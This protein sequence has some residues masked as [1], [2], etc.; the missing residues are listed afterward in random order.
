MINRDLVQINENYCRYRLKTNFTTVSFQILSQLS[1]VMREC[2]NQKPRAR[3][4]VLR[5]KKTLRKLWEDAQDDT[6]I[7]KNSLKNKLIT[8]KIIE[9]M[10]DV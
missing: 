8:E 1:R 3:L 10:V 7:E 6:L 9:K 4:T 5:L 2:W